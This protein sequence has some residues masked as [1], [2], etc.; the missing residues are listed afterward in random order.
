M[1]PH[2]IIVFV[3]FALVHCVLGIM[4]YHGYSPLVTYR[5]SKMTR[6]ESQTTHGSWATSRFP[7]LFHVARPYMLPEF[8]DFMG[9]CHLSRWTIQYCTIT[10][11]LKQ[12]FSRG[13]NLSK[14]TCLL[15]LCIGELFDRPPAP[16]RYGFPTF[17][18]PLLACMPCKLRAN[19]C[20]LSN[21]AY[22]LWSPYR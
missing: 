4:M 9:C 15:H 2:E 14:N 1:C 11:L 22:R 18:W 19:R 5:F 8:L 12:S 13:S 6:P 7:L 16:P 17:H 10:R 21:L 3:Q 20:D